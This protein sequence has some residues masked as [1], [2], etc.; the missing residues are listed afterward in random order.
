MNKNK[1][2][3][4]LNIF[5]LRLLRAERAKALWVYYNPGHH[6]NLSGVSRSC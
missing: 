4:S 6:R 5:A 2:R 3:F 1:V